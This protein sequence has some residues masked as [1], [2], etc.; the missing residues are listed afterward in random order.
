MLGFGA[1]TPIAGT[2]EGVVDCAQE[3]VFGFIGPGF[4]DNYRKWCPQVVELEPLESVQVA[5]GRRARQVTEDRGVRTESTFELTTLAPVTRVEIK[6]LTDP[7]RSA[8]EFS[9]AGDATKIRF[10]FEL[11]EIDLAMRP[12][13]KLI[14]AALQEGAAQTVAN[15]KRLLEEAE[16]K[17]S[18]A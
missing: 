17:R 8:Y 1:S 5:V 14:R 7:F 10:M 4:Y 6:G 18:A 3:R 15:L 13:Q 2:A 12:F 9:P 16:P 11:A